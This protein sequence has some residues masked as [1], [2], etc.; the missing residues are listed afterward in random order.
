MK[1]VAITGTDVKGCTYQMKEC[2]L[3]ELREGNIITE[4][5]LPRD[6]PHFCL[7]CKTCFFGNEENCPHATH[8]MPIWNSILESDLIVFAYPVYVLRTPGQVKA[9]LDHFGSHWMAHRPEPAMF[10]KRA[11]ILTQSVGAPNGPAQKDVATSLTW[12]GV[13]DVKKLGLGLM[14]GVYWEELSEKRR[15]VILT[16]TRAF[17][18]Q[19]KDF[20][21]ASPSLQTKAIFFMCKQMRKQ[22]LAK[23]TEISYDSQY[24][25]D[26]G[27]IRRK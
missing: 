15:D 20:T 24:W 13:P 18:Q 10:R 11:A 5:T 12:L 21:E 1:I 22:V 3:D 25:I 2:F 23:E 26:R 8:I 27:W 19:F 14:E 6:N 9:L 17:A 16:K 7:G 4:Y